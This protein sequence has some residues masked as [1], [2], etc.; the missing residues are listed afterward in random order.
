MLWLPS[1]QTPS[2]CPAGGCNGREGTEG[3]GVFHTPIKEAWLRQVWSQVALP[4]LLTLAGCHPV[5]FTSPNACYHYLSL[6]CSCSGVRWGLHP[7]PCLVHRECSVSPIISPII[8]QW[9]VSCLYHGVKCAF[10]ALE[11][12]AAHAVIG[13]PHS[14]PDFSKCTKCHLQSSTVQAWTHSALL[15]N[16]T[17]MEVVSQKPSES[18]TNCKMLLPYFKDKEDWN[19]SNQLIK[20]IWR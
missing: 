6:R 18:L 17:W 10:A 14:A 13:S 8:W 11:S 2:S 19:F 7:E 9:Q 1:S 3:H 4:G 5:R 15:K 20:S 12:N 16:L